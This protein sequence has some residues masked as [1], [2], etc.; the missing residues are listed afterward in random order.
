ML[1]QGTEQEGK[2][3][4]VGSH[5]MRNLGG[6]A[7]SCPRSESKRCHT[8]TFSRTVQRTAEDTMGT[9]PL[10]IYESITNLFS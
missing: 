7:R 3:E 4:D 8:A 9:K 10:F 5:W 6:C 1:E 2:S